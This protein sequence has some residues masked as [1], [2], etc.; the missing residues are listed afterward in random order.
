MYIFLELLTDCVEFGLWACKWFI[1]LFPP[2][3]HS[4][5]LNILLLLFFF[6]DPVGYPGDSDINC[7]YCDTDVK[8]NKECRHS[9]ISHFSVHKASVTWN[10]SRNVTWNWKCKTTVSSHKT[11]Y[12]L[13]PFTFC[14]VDSHREPPVCAIKRRRRPSLI[15]QWENHP[16][17]CDY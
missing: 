16:S 10:D 12:C 4:P 5:N 11:N 14:M 17:L 13:V 8:R 2:R 3:P 7:R 1:P 9:Y 6:F 15:P